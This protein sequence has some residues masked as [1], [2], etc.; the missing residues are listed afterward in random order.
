MPDYQNGKIYRLI[1]SQTSKQY[2]GSTCAN[3]KK[4]LSSHKVKYNSTISRELI[5]PTIELIEDYPCKTKED[6]FKRERYYIEKLR[7]INLNKPIV[8]EEERRE[9]CR[10][11]NKLWYKKN[12]ESHK[13]TMK[14]RYDLK[15]DEI[16]HIQKTKNLCEVCCA[17]VSKRN[18]ARHLLSNKHTK[19]QKML[20]EEN[21]TI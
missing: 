21:I 11:Q 10:I 1:C 14:E 13:K 15:K 9:V 20:E 3:L 12:T 7:C 2:I 17:C 8:S 6:L 19:N 4:R 5:N 16:N 18:W